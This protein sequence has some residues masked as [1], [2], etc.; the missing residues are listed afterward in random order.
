MRGGRGEGLAA[1]TGKTAMKQNV[2]IRNGF[3]DLSIVSYS[4]VFRRKSSPFLFY[5][6][7]AAVALSK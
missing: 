5:N 3:E 4:F 2:R 1:Q 6:L 7:A